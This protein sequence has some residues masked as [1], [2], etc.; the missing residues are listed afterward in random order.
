[1]AKVSAIIINYNAGNIL[2]QAVQ[3]LLGS[4]EVTEVFVVDNA[5]MDNSMAPIDRLA[6][7]SCVLKCIHNTNN[8]GFA[9]ACNMAL[10]AASNDFLLLLNPDCIMKPEAIKTLLARMDD[11]PQAGMV[12]PLLLNPDGTEQAGGRRAVPT[13]WLSFIRAFGLVR[14]KDRYP[15]LF[16]DFLLHEKPLPDKPVE[17]EAISGSCM[18]VRR[19]ALEDVGNMD[20]GYFLHCEDLDWCIRFRRNNWKIFFVPDASVVHFQRTCSKARPVFVEWH[21]HKGMMRF[22]DK[23]FRDQYPGVLFW[24]VGVGVWLRFSML[25]IFHTVQKLKHGINRVN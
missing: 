13:P 25:A 2:Q 21:K 6:K 15:N 16:P 14:F 22:Y 24:I 17:V 7:S 1:M 3:T 8:V 10:D 11:F 4:K 18:L 23:F 5:S 20:E 12:G 19:S 9:K